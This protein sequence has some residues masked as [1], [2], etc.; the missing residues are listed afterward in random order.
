MSEYNEENLHDYILDQIHNIGEV[1]PESF[2]KVMDEE[3]GLLVRYLRSCGIRVS[4]ARLKETEKDRI[5]MELDMEDPDCDQQ[6]EIR[7]LH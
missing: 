5:R 3:P 4:H 2:R 7:F 1:S 6:F